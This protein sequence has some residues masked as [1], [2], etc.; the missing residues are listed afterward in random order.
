M[1]R[2]HIKDEGM[3][4]L[5]EVLSQTEINTLECAATPHCATHVFACMSRA[6]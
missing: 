3:I 1:A 6:R 5:A 2:N 4:K